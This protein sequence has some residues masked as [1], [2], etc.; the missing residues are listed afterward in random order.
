M[1]DVHFPL[2]P[3]L[4]PLS[5]SL[6]PFPY[7]I[8]LNPLLHSPYIFCINWYNALN[9]IVSSFVA[10]TALFFLFI[11]HDIALR[12]SKTDITL[13]DIAQDRFSSHAYRYRF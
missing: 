3:S 11:S 5:L 10:D 6:S 12:T 1:F 2:H 4:P 9:E 8:L 13:P 7:P